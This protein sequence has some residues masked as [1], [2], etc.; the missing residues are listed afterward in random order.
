MVRALPRQSKVDAD[1]WLTAFVGDTKRRLLSLLSGPFRGMSI[2]LALAVLEGL[3]S[4]TVTSKEAEKELTKRDGVASRGK[5]Q[6]DELS[7]YLTLHDLKRLE[8]YGR[9]LCDHHL[10]TD[11]LPAVARLYFL[12]RLGD[13]FSLSSVQAALLCG[14]GVQ[15]RKV[16]DL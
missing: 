16:D 1:A 11:L 7:Y 14:I 5:I 8:L 6:V 4:R 2:R 9:N 15:S 3:N 12:S 10:V 13:A